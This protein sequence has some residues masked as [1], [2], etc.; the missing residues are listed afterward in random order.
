VG[1]QHFN[2]CSTEVGSLI[3]MPA[4]MRSSSRGRSSDL[5][6][7][8]HGFWRRDSKLPTINR[9]A[10]ERE[11]RGRRPNDKRTCELAGRVFL[12]FED[13]PGILTSPLTSPTTFAFDLTM[14]AC[15]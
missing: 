5:S 12:A 14:P 11:Q 13:A 15:Q 9:Y 1:A 2:G 7:P 10:I 8:S 4:A 3:A 6:C